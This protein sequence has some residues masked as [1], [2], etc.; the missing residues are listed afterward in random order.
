MTDLNFSNIG[1]VVELAVASSLRK[2][3]RYV[4][5]PLM[6]PELRYD[7]IVLE[8]DGS[9]K[10]VQCKT[11]TLDAGAIIFST[12]NTKFHLRSNSKIICTTQG[13]V[14]DIDY[15]GVYCFENEKSYLVPIDGLPK[16]LASLRVDPYKIKRKKF[17]R[18]ADDY[19]IKPQKLDRAKLLAERGFSI[20]PESVQCL[21]CDE[22]TGRFS[23]YCSKCS[24]VSR[25]KVQRPTS[26]QLEREI[27]SMNW[28]A[29]GKKY[30]V[31]DNAVRK[32]ARYY[33]LL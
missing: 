2:A 24:G 3:G 7:L 28:T 14:G 18:W 13:Y 1:G 27:R 32:W 20:K 30:G 9:F 19:E 26:E 21:T 15:F 6:A 11:G 16:R 25:R 12:S 10:R 22:Q 31:T 5:V 29:V 17:A 4:F 33:G 8:N 23:L